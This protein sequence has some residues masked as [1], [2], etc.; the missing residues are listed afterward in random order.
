[1]TDIKL[2][3][4][5][6]IIPDNLT[7]LDWDVV[8]HGRPYYVVRIEGY[9]HSIG[10]RWSENDFWAYPRDEKPCYDN[11]IEFSGEPVIWAI[12][13]EPENYIEF[14]W[15]EKRAQCSGSAIITRN[16]E[17]FCSISGDMYYSI[18]KARTLITEINEGPVDVNA[19]DYDKKLIGRKVYWRGEPAVVESF[20]KG[21]ACVIIRPDMDSDFNTPAYYKDID[22]FSESIV[23]AEIW[24]KNIWWFR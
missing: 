11:L 2:I 20:V 9:V 12:R 15:G 16:G 22:Y 8:I 18:D 5:D 7:P 3:E 17:D 10:G 1:M 4:P 6:T 21:Q 14:K 24:D 23:K 19:I 13:Y